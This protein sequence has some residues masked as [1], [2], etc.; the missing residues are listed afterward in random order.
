M[1]IKLLREKLNGYSS[2]ELI[3]LIRDGKIPKI[4]D[5]CFPLRSFCDCGE[6]ALYVRIIF[7]HSG[8]LRYIPKTIFLCKRCMDNGYKEI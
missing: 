4:A 7:V 8:F 1:D 5:E 3:D 2:R 6:R